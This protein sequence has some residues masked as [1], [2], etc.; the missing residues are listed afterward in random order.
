M[1]IKLPFLPWDLNIQ[2]HARNKAASPPQP[3][4]PPPPQPLH[5][6]S[7][8]QTI[9]K[10]NNYNKIFCIGSNKTGTTSLEKLFSLFGFE[11]GNQAAAEILSL[12]WLINQNAERIIKYC[13]TAE[14]FQDVPFS[15]PGLFKELDKAFPNSKF[16]LTVRNSP[17][18]WFKSLVRFHTNV[19]SSDPT[20]PPSEDELTNATY[21]YKGYAFEIMALLYGYPK[22]SLY[23]ESAYKNHYVTDNDEKRTYFKDRPNDFIE[24]NLAVKEDFL[25]LCDFL[26]VE[27]NINDFPWLNRSE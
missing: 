2:R 9:I 15:Y 20:R 19:F 23:D 12:D 27:T 8:P 4:P 25:R 16:I 17:D 13:Y 22:T 11:L 14:A 3:P 26:G 7:P 24:I 10:R 18:E 21:R 6:P 1:I 5:P